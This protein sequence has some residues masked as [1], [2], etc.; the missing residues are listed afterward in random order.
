MKILSIE[1]TNKHSFNS[2]LDL[3][4]VVVEYENGNTGLV[5][6]HRTK[7]DRVIFEQKLMKKYGITENEMILLQEMFFKEHEAEHFY[8]ED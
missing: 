7:Y 8:D 5:S 2:D 6:M 3:I 4:N 1:S